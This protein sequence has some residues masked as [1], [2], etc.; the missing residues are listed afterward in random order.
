MDII[1]KLV[2]T[3]MK[4]NYSKAAYGM[5][6]T[7]LLAIDLLELRAVGTSLFI[8]LFVIVLLV[9]SYADLSAGD[10]GSSSTIT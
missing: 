1:L 2:E 7:M 6:L 8:V 4:T 3:L 10:A 9:L 5:M